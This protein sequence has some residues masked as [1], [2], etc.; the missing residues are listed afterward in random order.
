MAK[1]IFVYICGTL[2]QENTTL[3]YLK[4]MSRRSLLMRIKWITTAVYA[5][6]FC[7]S[8]SHIHIRIRMLR[9]LTAQAI[10]Q[11]M[12]DFIPTLHPIQDS[13]NFLQAHSNCKTW[14]VSATLTE[15]ASEI[16]HKQGLDHVIASTLRYSSSGI[17]TGEYS[18]FLLD[19]GKLA[20]VKKELQPIDISNAEY[21]TDD[22]IA[23]SDLCNAV[24]KIHAV[25]N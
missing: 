2:Y 23:D 6:L 13:F 9:G 5:K 20:H 10:K 19:E 14:L 12:Q 7:N 4:F 22:V 24:L 15:I 25:S 21:I 17:C 16:Q 8:S 1:Y 11:S 18:S 3:A